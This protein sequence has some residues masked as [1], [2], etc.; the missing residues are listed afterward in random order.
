[1]IHGMETVW[2]SARQLPDTLHGVIRNIQQTG[3]APRPDSLCYGR[4]LPGGGRTRHQHDDQEFIVR[5]DLLAQ[6]LAAALNG[7]QAL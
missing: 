7:I 5:T 3:Q 6:R 4:A 1:M 2:P